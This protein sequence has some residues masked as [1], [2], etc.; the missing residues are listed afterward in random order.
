MVQKGT[1]LTTPLHKKKGEKK[2]SCLK[3][4]NSVLVGEKIK[5]LRNL[6]MLWQFL[7]YQSEDFLISRRVLVG[8][9]F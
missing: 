4:K 3:I 1:G 7:D 8:C 9:F 6:I 5:K 2:P